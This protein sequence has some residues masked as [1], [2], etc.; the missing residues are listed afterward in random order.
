MIDGKKAERIAC[1]YMR[2]KRYKLIDYNY[3]TRF[4]E[5]D[6]IFEKREG[7]KNKYIVFAEVKKR[8]IDSLAEPKEYVDSAKQQKIIMAAKEY[9][10]KSKS[11]LQPRFDVIEIICNNDE[12]ISIKHL[13]NAFTIS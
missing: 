3:R 9:I 4:G 8:N 10:A 5:I 13:E 6:L 12:V 1:D 11:T 2:D 7:L